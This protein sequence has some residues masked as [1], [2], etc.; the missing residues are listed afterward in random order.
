MEFGMQHNEWWEKFGQVFEYVKIIRSPSEKKYCIDEN[1][2]LLT[3]VTIR[4]NSSID[5]PAVARFGMFLCVPK[6]DDEYRLALLWRVDT[7]NIEDASKQFGKI[8]DAARCC[9][10][11]IEH[12]SPNGSMKPDYQYLGPNCCR[13]GQNVS[14]TCFFLC[15]WHMKY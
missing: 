6:E 15:I 1:P 11:L 10:N 3:V 2:V 8:L 14:T 5:D 12:L 9:A 4:Q 13:I 7:T